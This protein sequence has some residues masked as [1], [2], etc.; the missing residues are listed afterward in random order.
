MPIFMFNSSTS[1]QIL[2]ENINT[3]NRSW[4]RWSW[5]S[6]RNHA[7][8]SCPKRRLALNNM[9]LSLCTCMTTSNGHELC[10]LTSLTGIIKIRRLWRTLWRSTCTLIAFA[11]QDLSIS[12]TI[13]V[14][15]RSLWFSSRYSL[16]WSISTPWFLNL[17]APSLR[18]AV[19]GYLV[20]A[21]MRQG[22]SV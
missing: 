9:Q 18:M 17:F 4:R 11:V 14:I 8:R 21:S 13:V 3:F 20:N 19:F 16:T 22:R 15:R 7:C 10:F 5:R 2:P 6:F 1:T 12:S